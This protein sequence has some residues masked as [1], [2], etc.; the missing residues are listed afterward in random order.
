ME[1]SAGKLSKGNKGNPLK[2]GDAEEFVQYVAAGS[3]SD[4]VGY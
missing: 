2:R 3:V 4:L 1:K